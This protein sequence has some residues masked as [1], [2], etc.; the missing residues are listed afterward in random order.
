[1]KR[2]CAKACE[3]TTG[4]PVRRGGRVLA[5][6]VAAGLLLGAAPALAAPACKNVAVAR[7]VA[8][9]AYSP[10][11]SATLAATGQVTYDCPPPLAPAISLSAG[12]SGNVA[13]RTM[14]SATGDRLRYNLYTDAA[15]TAVWG[16]TPIPVPATNGGVVTIYGCVPALQVVG[17]G[18][19]SDTIWVTFNF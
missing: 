1:M 12:G 9:G 8:F 2:L 6:A 4:G 3:S 17:A 7:P 10:F 11:S 19:Y 13:A 16:L 5:V 15:C 14:A 18:A